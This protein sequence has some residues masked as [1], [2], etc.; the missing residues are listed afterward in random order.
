MPATCPKIAT[1]NVM[2]KGQSVQLWVGPADKQGPIVFYWHGTGSSS[3]EAVS[4]LGPGLNEIMSQGGVAASFTTTTS[5]GM[6]TGN[7]VWYTGDYEMADEIL[8][9]AVAQGLVNTRQIYAA[10]CSAGGLQSGSML[11]G[12][13]SYLAAVMPNSGGTTFRF[14]LE[15]PAHVPALITAHGGS[16]DMVG[17]SFAMTSATEDKDVAAKGGLVV[18]CNHGGGHCGSP[19]DLKAAQWK[20]LKDHPFGSPDPYAGTLPAGFPSYCMIIK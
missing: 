7:N 11:Y 17:V 16:S 1:G 4:G 6:N 20:F 13:S 9:C 19:A 8:A 2:V 18:N 15:D 3:A 10:G 5:A 12:R 14:Q